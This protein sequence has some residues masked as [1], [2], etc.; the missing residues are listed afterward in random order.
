MGAEKDNSEADESEDAEEPGENTRTIPP[1]H[2]AGTGYRIGGQLLFKNEFT[3]TKEVY[4]E[5]VKAFMGQYRKLYYIMAES[6]LFSGCSASLGS[7]QFRYCIPSCGYH[8][9]GNAVF[10][11]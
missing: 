6:V 1:I 11:L 8:M 3:I 7:L 5:F 10:P 2:K 9:S 4:L